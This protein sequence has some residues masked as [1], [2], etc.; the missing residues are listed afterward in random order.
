[1]TLVHWLILLVV[2]V[3]LFIITRLWVGMVDA[4]FEKVKRLF[5]GNRSPKGN[6]HTLEEKE[7]EDSDK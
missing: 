4:I 7:E 5:L 3:I 6:W 1:M 2:C